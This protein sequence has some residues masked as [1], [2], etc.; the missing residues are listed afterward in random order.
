MNAVKKPSIHYTLVSV[1]GCERTTSYCPASEGYRDYHDSGWTPREPEQHTAR[2]E[3]EIDWG[4]GRH[5]MLKL[6]GHQHRDIG[7]YDK[8]PELLEAIGSGDQPE[9]ALQDALTVASRPA[10]AG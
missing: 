3:L 5:Q 8:L 6:E 4:G 7:M 2:A 1:D 9:T 10:M